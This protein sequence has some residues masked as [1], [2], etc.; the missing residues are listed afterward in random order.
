MARRLQA[1]TLLLEHAP[2]VKDFADSIYISARK[3]GI[4]KQRSAVSLSNHAVLNGKVSVVIPCR[5]EAANITDLIDLLL[6]YYNPYIHEILI[7]NDNSSDNTIEVVC[8]L[9]L[10]DPRI[11][12]LNRSKPNG[13]GRALRDGYRAASGQ[14]IL[15]MDCDFIN[16]L[17]EFRGLF[18]VI[19][20]GHDGAIGSRF[21]HES[22]I[23][24]YPFS[25]MVCNRLFHLLVKLVVHPGVRD[26]TNNLKLYRSEIFK[27]LEIESPHFSANLETGLKPLLEGYDIKEVP[28]SWINR[29]PE[30]GASSFKLGVVGGDYIRA[31]VHIWLTD[32][33]RKPARKRL[34]GSPA[35]MPE[36]AEVSDDELEKV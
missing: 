7:V 17:P 11:K 14:Y 31:L 32:R 22:V 9:S 28:I 30:M 25:K 26:V 34:S 3:P 2:V 19:A 33:F 6:A 5:N 13:V 21:S 16:I 29:T 10:R 12:L 4:R 8:E 27:S 1:K 35:R 36:T 18:D 20:L 15:S 24:N 23:L